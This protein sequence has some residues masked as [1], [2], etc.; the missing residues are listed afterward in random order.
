MEN[1]KLIIQSIL[2]LLKIRDILRLM[3]ISPFFLRLATENI[4]IISDHPMSAALQTVWRTTII[5]NCI[6]E[7]IQNDNS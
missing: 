7:K 5:I 6:V 2:S 1:E 3:K 4:A